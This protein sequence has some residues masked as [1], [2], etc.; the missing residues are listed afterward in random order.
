MKDPRWRQRKTTFREFL[1]SDVG[2]ATGPI[3]GR[4]VLLEI[5]VMPV[6]LAFAATLIGVIWI[7][8]R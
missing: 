8:V 7:A 2:T 5:A 1:D 6:S 3:S 4:E